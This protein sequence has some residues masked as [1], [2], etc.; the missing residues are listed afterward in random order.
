M[1]VQRVLAAAVFSLF[2]S[3]CGGGSE[4]HGARGG[5]ASVAS[6]EGPASIEG[7]TGTA[8]N[9]TAPTLAATFSSD[10]STF[11][12]GEIVTVRVDPTPSAPVAVGVAGN[13]VDTVQDGSDVTV[14]VPNL[15]S[16]T[17][18]LTL[19]VNGHTAT[20][21]FDIVD[22]PL[23]DDLREF[24]RDIIAEAIQL[25]DQHLVTNPDDA[26]AKDLRAQ[27][28]SLQAALQNMTD[29]EV[30]ELARQ[31]AANPIVSAELPESCSAG[32]ANYETRLQALRRTIALTDLLY[33]KHLKR[34]VDVT[35][36]A[37]MLAKA[38]MDASLVRFDAF[39]TAT[40]SLCNGDPSI[41]QG[42]DNLRASKNRSSAAVAALQ[43]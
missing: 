14:V 18:T 24:V 3:A 36:M 6:G 26:A 33:A 30:A 22:L 28:A 5:T 29:D 17:H 20:L 41:S 43:R 21:T 1:F 19:S 2:I 38:R 4:S 27:L 12:A 42:A 16:G 34:K 32:K 7:G 13:P 31:L 23:P 10:T 25:I 15:P 8:N 35:H 39:V 9:G 37:V 40:T 11:V